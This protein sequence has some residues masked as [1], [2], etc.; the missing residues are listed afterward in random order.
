MIKDE[1]FEGRKIYERLDNGIE[2]YDA[3]YF[4]Q[5]MVDFAH[6]IM[7]AFIITGII[8]FFLVMIFWV[9]PY[10]LHLACSFPGIPTG[11]TLCAN[12]R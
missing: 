12:W 7:W 3:E 11:S 6:N 5:P 2:V 4:N 10:M 9:I 8:S 1:T